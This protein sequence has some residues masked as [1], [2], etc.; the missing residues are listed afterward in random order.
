MVLDSWVSVIKQEKHFSQSLVTSLGDSQADRL[1]HRV[2]SLLGT[3]SVWKVWTFWKTLYT[4]LKC[5][6][7][8]KCANEMMTG[9]I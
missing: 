1:S 6:K 4:V 5:E 8:L 9:C 3:Q 7:L 2:L